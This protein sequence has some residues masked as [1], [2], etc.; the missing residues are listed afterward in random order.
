M[1]INIHTPF[2]IKIAQQNYIRDIEDRL[3]ISLVNQFNYKMSMEKPNQKLYT[4]TLIAERP[5]G[6]TDLTNVKSRFIR[7]CQDSNWI[8][9][10]ISINECIF[11][12][13][14]SPAI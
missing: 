11:T 10:L 13:T 4:V 7:H 6:F 12:V 3:L 8:V 1:M 5:A 14:V 2:Q 9:R